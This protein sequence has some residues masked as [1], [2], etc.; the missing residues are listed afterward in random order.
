MTVSIDAQLDHRG[1]RLGWCGVSELGLSAALD[2]QVDSSLDGGL[3]RP[4]EGAPGTKIPEPTAEPA[5]GAVFA[6]PRTPRA[7]S[8]LGMVAEK[9]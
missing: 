8:R 7:E 2:G 5:S 1:R 6:H 4:L 3:W 9:R